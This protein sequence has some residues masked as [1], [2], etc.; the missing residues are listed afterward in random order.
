MEMTDAAGR[1]ADGARAASPVIDIHTHI[2]VPS[3]PDTD[4]GI[5][6]CRK[7]A[8][9]AGID[10]IV[11]LTNLGADPG[12][13]YVAEP[14]P[15]QIRASNDMACRLAQEHS[16]FIVSFCHLNPAHDP[17]FLDEEIDRCIRTGPCRGVKLWIAVRASDRRL[18]PILEQV[19]ELGVPVL[20]HSWYKSVGQY[21]GESTPADVA[22]LAARHPAA[23]VIMGHLS[24][25]R[26][27]GILDAKPYPNLMVETSGG[28]PDG[29][30]VKYAV[31]QLGPERVLFGSDWPGR[32]FGVQRARVDAAGLAEDDARLVLGGNAARLLKIGGH[33]N[34]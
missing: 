18:D 13:G 29:G 26:W 23:T 9:R 19:A 10:M 15:R 11:N 25:S 32:H 17:A 31:Q 27:H 7:L 6:T 28:Q 30:L 24:G 14:T 3:S 20:Q 22:D 1:S 8:A 5:A 21:P 12:S 2:G 33:R 16:D 4:D 34:V